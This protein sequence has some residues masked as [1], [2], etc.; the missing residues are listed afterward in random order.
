[1]EKLQNIEI[2]IIGKEGNNDLSPENY[3]IKQLA[4]LLKDVED[5]LFPNKKQIRPIV[6]YD[7]Q[8]GF[9]KTSLLF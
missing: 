8:K 2:K 7:I 9:S 1:M 5:L 6:S 4:S 3:D